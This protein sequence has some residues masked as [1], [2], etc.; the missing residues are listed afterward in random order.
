RRRRIVQEVEQLPARSPLPGPQVRE[1]LLHERERK[2]SAHGLA[3][4]EGIER[5]DVGVVVRSR[6]RLFR[7]GGGQSGQRGERAVVR[8]FLKE[9]ASSPHGFIP[10]PLTRSCSRR[11]SVMY[12]STPSPFHA[13]RPPPSRPS[14]STGAAEP[15]SPKWARRSFCER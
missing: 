1:L 4:H 14:T 2:L 13:Q 10:P 3:L 8:R 15:P 5:A 9:L 12:R 7:S 11:T 6:R